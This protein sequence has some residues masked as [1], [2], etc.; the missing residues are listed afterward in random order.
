MK[1][2]P[3]RHVETH[4]YSRFVDYLEGTL[5]TISENFILR[6]WPRFISRW[7]WTFR[8][9]TCI[10]IFGENLRDVE[11]V[12][13]VRRLNENAWYHD[14]ITVLMVEGEN[15]KE[16]FSQNCQ[17]EVDFDIHYEYFLPSAKPMSFNKNTVRVS[18]EFQNPKDA[19]LF[20]LRFG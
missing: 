20:K 9:Q 17:G 7:L 8:E 6:R 12:T 19:M 15:I 11:L 13:S 1:W 14:G 16:W 4:N 10:K 3:P 18:A 2:F 5:F